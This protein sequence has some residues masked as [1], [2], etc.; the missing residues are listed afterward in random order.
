MK[1]KFKSIAIAI[2][3]LLMSCCVFV[4]C[5]EDEKISTGSISEQV[6]AQAVELGY[7]GTYDEFIKLVSGKDGV[8][9][10]DG[11]GIKSVELNEKGELVINLTNDIHSLPSKM[12]DEKILK[13][14]I[15]HYDTFPFEEER[16]LF[17]VALTR[18]KNYCYL[19]VPKDNPS[20]FVSEL[21][22][23]YK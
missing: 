3:S 19:F 22:K 23:N 2:L 20:I 18:T 7:D 1:I 8:D 12:K 17:Y 15:K 4:A 6:Y 21:I 9:G 5:N 16:R 13:Y 11:V 10:K 14:V